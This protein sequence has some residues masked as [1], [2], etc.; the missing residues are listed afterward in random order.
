MK[1]SIVIPVYNSENSIGELV[2]VLVREFHDETLEIILV[3]D[4][5][6]D[7]SHGV[8]LRKFEQHPGI[9]RYLQL[10]R[11]FGEYNAVMAGLNH[12]SGDYIITMDDDFQNP[13]AEARRMLETMRQGD[14]DVLYT[15]FGE[16]RH[17]WFRN[18]GS[19]F[20]DKVATFLLEKPGDL[21][22]SSFK[23]MNA[24]IVAEII[25]YKGPY[26]F[27]DGLILRATR[28]IG[29]LQV[30][31]AERREGHSNYTL[32]KLIGVW[33]NM[34]TNFSVV[35]L[36]VSFFLGTLLTV[37][38]V[39]LLLYFLLAIYWLQP[40][41]FWPPGWP[42]LVV[43]II[44]FSGTQLMILGLLGE[45]LGKLFVSYNGRP[46]YVVRRAHGDT[47]SKGNAGA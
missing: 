7:N 5:S 31:H 34:C 27:I 41:E 44:T 18:F 1:V 40:E 45:Y 36:R 46:Q 4:G 47:S 20:N 23:C 6:R 33:L 2:D 26:P 8:C 22:L 15:Y 24:F 25:K 32:A 29:R 12:A 30:Q 21:Y 39:L 3:N 9:V 38:G 37:F 14:Y 42:T 19:W 11:N 35:P 17:H 10:A 16:K 43:C 13:P 28:N